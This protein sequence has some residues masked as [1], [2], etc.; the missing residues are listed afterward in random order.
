[1]T[2]STQ[3]SPE[4]GSTISV[5]PPGSPAFVRV[6]HVDT[7]QVVVARARWAAGFGSK[8][9]GLTF[10]RRL[11]A[12]EGL[13]LVENRTSRVDTAIHMFFVFFP[14]AAVWIG[15]D[16]KVVDRKLARPFR[17]AYVPAGPARFVLESSPELLDHIQPGDRLLFE[18]LDA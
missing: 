18:P 9:R 7:G 12:G 11:A 6:R 17:P 16:G 15:E 10:R 14:I 4:A 13:V 3:R 8:L 1:M 5:L 2:R